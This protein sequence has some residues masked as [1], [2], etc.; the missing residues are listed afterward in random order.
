MSKEE[1]SMRLRGTVGIVA[2]SAEELW[3]CG[4]P[5]KLRRNSA[6]NVCR[7]GATSCAASEFECLAIICQSGILAAS[8]FLLVANPNINGVNFPTYFAV[9]AARMHKVSLFLYN[10]FS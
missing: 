3:S 8:V 7:S 2:K 5:P 1:E 4:A 10:L 9:A 6:H